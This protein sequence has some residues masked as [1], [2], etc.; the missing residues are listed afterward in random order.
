MRYQDEKLTT[1][2]AGR[3]DKE[4]NLRDNKKVQPGLCGSVI[5]HRPGNLEVMVRIQSGHMPGL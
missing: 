5:E 4:T 2:V 1:E 3:R